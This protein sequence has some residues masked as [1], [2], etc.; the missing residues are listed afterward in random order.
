MTETCKYRNAYSSH[1]PLY[2]SYDTGL[3]NLFKHQTILSLVHISCILNTC[4]SDQAREC[5]EKLNA[6][7]KNGA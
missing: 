6:G 3:E 4:M 2:I 5:K 7:L 1:C